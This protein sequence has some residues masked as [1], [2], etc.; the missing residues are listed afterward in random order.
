MKQSLL[1]AFDGAVRGQAD[2]R[3]D[4][5]VLG[6]PEFGITGGGANLDD[7]VDAAHPSITGMGCK[8]GV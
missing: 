4:V 8:N 2:G 1:L 3:H 7:F 5:P 6:V